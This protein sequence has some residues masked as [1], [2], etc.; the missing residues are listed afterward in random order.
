MSED[1]I[2]AA[3]RALAQQGLYVE[4][5]AAAAPAAALRLGQAVGEAVIVL[6]GTGLKATDRAVAALGL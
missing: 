6:S 1:E 5:T 3:W 4:P 2:A